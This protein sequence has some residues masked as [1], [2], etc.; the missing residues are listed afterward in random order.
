[1]SVK[2]DFLSDF[3]ALLTKWNATIEADD[4]YKGYPECG[5]DIRI[6]VDIEAIYTTEGETIR[7]YTEIDLGRYVDPK[8]DARDAIAGSEHERES[9]CPVCR[10]GGLHPDGRFVACPECGGSGEPGEREKESCSSVVE[11]A[12]NRFKAI[13]DSLE[14][15]C[16]SYNG[17]TCSVHADRVLA[18][19][20]LQRE[21]ESVCETL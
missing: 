21:Q 10:G 4:H 13:V 8:F 1:M 17:F 5:Q 19:K 9:P 16:D 12:L 7:P 15:E 18:E 14:C 6:I 11:S 3:L 20:A 2:Q